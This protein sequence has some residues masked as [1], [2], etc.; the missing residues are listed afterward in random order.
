MNIDLLFPDGVPT[1][2]K[3]II[4]NTYG[5]GENTGRVK[6]VMNMV[7]NMCWPCLNKAKEQYRRRQ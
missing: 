2:P 1:A 6:T 5:E 4:C 3:C 7:G